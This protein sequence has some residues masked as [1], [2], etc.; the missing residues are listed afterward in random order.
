MSKHR[1]EVGTSSIRIHNYDWGDSERLERQFSVWNLTCHRYDPFGMSY[2]EDQRILYLPRGID[3][4]YVQ[5]CLKVSTEEL[6]FL[7][8]NAYE[9]FDGVK[10]KYGPRDALQKEAIRFMLGLAEYQKNNQY[11]CLLVSSTTGFGKSYCSIFTM[12]YTHRKSCVIT[13]SLSILDQWADYIFK[14][15]NMK[16]DDVYLI[17]GSDSINMILK[18]RTKYMSSKVYLVSHA[19][20]R[21]Y[22]NTYG[23][24]K[25]DLLFKKIK[26]GNV[27]IDE[28]HR[29]FDNICKINAHINVYKTYFVTATPA[30]SS[31]AENRIYQKAMKNVPTISLY[32]PDINKHINYI[33]M[34]YYSDPNPRDKSDMFN[35][36]GIDKNKYVNY[37]VHQ[38]NFYKILRVVMNM[39]IKANGPCVF[40]IDTNEAILVVYKWLLI[41]YPEF[42]GDIGLFS[43]LVSS[44]VKAEEKQKRLILTTMKSGSTGEDIAGLKMAVVL[45]AP[46]KSTVTAI[47]CAGRLRDSGTYF[48]ELV[49]LSFQSLAKFYYHKLP[50]YNQYMLS[51]TD[52]NFSRQKLN[53]KAEDLEYQQTSRN[54]K[55]PI[56]AVDERFGIGIF[57]LILYTDDEADELLKK[58]R[59]RPE[60]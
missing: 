55:V 2:D 23:W 20:L 19:T 52:Y 48:I 26:V 14:Y 41:N 6:V 8:P 32:N 21:D 30:R 37:V 47:Q 16:K 40:F 53:E 36:Y 24:D 57:P 29:E 13:Y 42:S 7:K 50:T 15:T 27:F 54:S 59:E 44:D 10:L 18:E 43:G 4:Y 3:L 38:P 39:V 58:M 11:S 9:E 51:V 35:M 22:G 28:A 17:K 56:R 45:A 12:V 31:D 1:I 46:F 34:K 60:G 25:I 33:A 49:D 5:G